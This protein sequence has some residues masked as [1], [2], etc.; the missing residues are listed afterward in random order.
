MEKSIAYWFK[1]GTSI[2]TIPSDIL[3]VLL[4]ISRYES[5]LWDIKHHIETNPND[6]DTLNT[7]LSYLNYYFYSK[8]SRDFEYFLANYDDTHLEPVINWELIKVSP[9]RYFWNHDRIPLL[10]CGI[11]FWGGLIREQIK[12]KTPRFACPLFIL[13]SLMFSYRFGGYKL[14]T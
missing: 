14:P 7:K 1:F 8:I 9:V 5:N 3:F 11:L 2:L 13:N 12:I 10:S 4:P 6:V